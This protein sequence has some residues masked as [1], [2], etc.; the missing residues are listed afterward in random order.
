MLYLTLSLRFSLYLFLLHRLLDDKGYVNVNF[1]ERFWVQINGFHM[2]YGDLS[3]F[4]QII[5]YSPSVG[6]LKILAPNL[7]NFRWGGH[8]VDYHCIEDFLSKLNLITALKLSD[9]LYKSSTKYYLKGIP[10][11]QHDFCF[12]IYSSVVT[13][14]YFIFNHILNWVFLQTRKDHF[15]LYLYLLA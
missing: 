3:Y 2:Q 15:N 12:I 4:I 8:V 9:Q 1:F 11:E 13:L 7:E 14:P 6:S 5:Y 10:I